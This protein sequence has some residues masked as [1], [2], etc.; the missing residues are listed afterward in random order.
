MR[1]STGGERRCP[2]L[3]PV[4]RGSDSH[5]DQRHEEQAGV[6]H[7]RPGAGRRVTQAV[8]ELVAQAVVHPPV[9]VGGVRTEITK[10]QQTILTALEVSPPS[11][12]LE[13]APPA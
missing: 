7:G 13:A 5:K 3:R 9:H 6:G 2:S 8:E 1:Y 12:I 10:P 11:R 4:R